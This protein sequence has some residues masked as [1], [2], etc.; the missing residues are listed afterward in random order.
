LEANLKKKVEEMPIHSLSAMKTSIFFCP[1]IL[2]LLGSEPPK[3]KGILARTES[4]IVNYSG[5][6]DFTWTEFLSLVFLSLQLP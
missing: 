2:E 5:S 1:W 6:K 4:H 3:F